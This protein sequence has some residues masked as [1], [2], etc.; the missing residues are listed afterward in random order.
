MSQPVENTTDFAPKNA[1]EDVLDWTQLP[2]KD[3][4]AELGEGRD[5]DP[6]PHEDTARR[7]IAYALIALLWA[8]VGAVLFLLY[9]ETVKIAEVKEFSV[10]VGP[11]VTLVS[12]ATGFYYGTKSQ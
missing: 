11:I 3:R 10:L 12:A 5:Y 6:R 9:N 2:A 7:Y 8:L 4:P 1:S